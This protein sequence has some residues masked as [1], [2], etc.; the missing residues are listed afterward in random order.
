MKGLFMKYHYPDS[1]L[2]LSCIIISILMAI[3]ITKYLVLPIE[4]IRAKRVQNG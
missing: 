4:K 3:T 2:G 1:Y